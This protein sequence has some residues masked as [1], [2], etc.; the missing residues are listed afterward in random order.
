[1]VW[2]FMNQLVPSFIGLWLGLNVVAAVVIIL[3]VLLKI[4]QRDWSRRATA[5]HAFV[6]DSVY[7]PSTTGNRS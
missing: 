1:M 5:T 2:H 6:N 3:A 4:N 7:Y